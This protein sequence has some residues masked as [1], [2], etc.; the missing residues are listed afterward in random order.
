MA[1]F[2]FD[3][4][5]M[6]LSQSRE[7]QQHQSVRMSTPHETPEKQSPQS[8]STGRDYFLSQNPTEV[9]RL[10]YQHVVIKDYMD[11]NLVLAPLDLSQSGLHILDS[12][13]AD[14]VYSVSF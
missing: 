13:T 3:K 8:K 12:A 10:N 1:A 6:I 7:Q 4:E 14:G 11:E 9:E 5:P 2:A